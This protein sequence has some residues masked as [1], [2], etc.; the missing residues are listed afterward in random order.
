[1]KIQRQTTI[2]ADSEAVWE[3]LARR[4][5]QV[6]EWASSVDRSTARAGA[7]RVPGAP[8][9][10]RTC[11]TELGP[12][13]EAILEFDEDRK[14]LAYSAAGE[15][16]PFFVKSLR[17]RW[18]L[19]AES[20]ARTRIDMLMTADLAIPFNVFMAP[21]MKL[22]MGKILTAVMEE[23]KHFVETGEPH[24]RKVNATRSTRKAA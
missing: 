4:F 16:M 18:S 15:K 10:G 24:P 19:T 6:D 11:E 7:P 23:L 1:M 5:D 20:G 14:V 21:V 9:L 2:N 12:F 22:Q 8:V 13:T 17:N 3:V